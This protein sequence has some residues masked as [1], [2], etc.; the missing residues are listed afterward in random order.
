MNIFH[1]YSLKSLKKNKT[2]T[3][4]TI[5][6]IILSVAMIT[7]VTTMVATIQNFGISYVIATSGDWHVYVNGVD[8]EK[9][10]SFYGDDRVATTYDLRNVGYAYLEGCVNE[11]K[12]YLCIL[13]TIAEIWKQSK[14]QSLREWVKKMWHMYKTK[15]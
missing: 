14:C 13:L 1:I 15:Y 6:G 7:A 5:I 11:Y 12:P 4:V 2:R 3:L 9:R 10:Q 8:S